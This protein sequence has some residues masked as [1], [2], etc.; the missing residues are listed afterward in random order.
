MAF[1][2]WTESAVRDLIHIAAY[3]ANDSTSYAKLT[4]DRI[5]LQAALA[6]RNPFY[7]RKVPEI[8]DESIRE[9]IC[10]SYRIIYHIH[11]QNRVDV[12]TVFHTSRLL[13]RE[14]INLKIG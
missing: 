12:I 4:I 11:S 5:R 9:I 8:R 3:I 13:N 10:G 2:N 14:S 6:G 1:L 7:G